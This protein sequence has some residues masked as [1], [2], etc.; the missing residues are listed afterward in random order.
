V[1]LAVNFRRTILRHPNVAAVL[2]E[3]LPRDVL[4]ALYDGAAR[5]LHQA[6]V[7]V[8][9]HALIIDGLE[10]LTVGAALIQATKSSGGR[11]QLFPSLDR[12]TEPALAKA[13]DANP[14]TS[15]EE[16][17][18]EVVRSTLRGVL[19]ALDDGPS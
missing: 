15:A 16:L 10:T 6:G 1:A 5:R 14:W 19:S 17:F 7:P 3:F 12:D 13:V 2:L 11:V 9:L 8:E 4:S 18:S